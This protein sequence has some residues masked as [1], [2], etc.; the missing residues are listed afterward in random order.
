MYSKKIVVH[1]SYIVK[2]K[3]E[4]HFTQRPK[5]VFTLSQLHRWPYRIL[6][7]HRNHSLFNDMIYRELGPAQIWIHDCRTTNDSRE[8]VFPVWIFNTSTV[9]VR[10]RNGSISDKLSNFIIGIKHII[11]YDLFNYIKSVVYGST[12]L[13]I[14]TFKIC[15]NVIRKIYID[16]APDCRL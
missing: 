16:I 10:T 15:F 8:T 1:S 4:R 3:R 9:N 12:V 7:V 6:F 13:K 11:K 2:S 14:W 5:S